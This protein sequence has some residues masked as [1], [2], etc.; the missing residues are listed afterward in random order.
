MK[1]ANTS[2]KIG[3]VG[4]CP[5]E[6]STKVRFESFDVEMSKNSSAKIID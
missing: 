5:V 3:V 1:T 4:Q 2:L 6:K